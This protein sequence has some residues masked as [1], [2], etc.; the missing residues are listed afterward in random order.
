MNEL[1]GTLESHDHFKPLTRICCTDIV[2][3]VIVTRC[4]SY[5]TSKLMCAQYTAVK[6]RIN[7]QE[8]L[9]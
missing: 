1:S 8:E 6:E 9:L 2:Y 4:S 7:D 3:V 5:H